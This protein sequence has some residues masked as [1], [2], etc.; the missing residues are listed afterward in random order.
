MGEMTRSPGG[1][2]VEDDGWGWGGRQQRRSP[3]FSLGAWGVGRAPS[4]TGTKRRSRFVVW[5][6]E[7]VRGPGIITLTVLIFI[8]CNIPPRQ[9]AQEVK[10]PS[11]T[12]GL[13]KANKGNPVCHKVLVKRV[14]AS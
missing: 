2:A 8:R 1:L 7:S 5:G 11:Q 9:A 10:S 3:G 4:E 6:A 14:D 13:R 12:A